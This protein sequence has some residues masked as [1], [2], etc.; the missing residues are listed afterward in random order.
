MAPANATWVSAARA[1][2]R[3]VITAAAAAESDGEAG[4]HHGSAV[5]TVMTWNVQLLAVSVGTPAQLAARAAKLAARIIELSADVVCLQEVFDARARAALLQGLAPA[6]DVAYAPA[7][8][9]R[10]GLVILARGGLTLQATAFHRFSGARGAEAWLFDKGAAGALLL[11]PA[12]RDGEV[13]SDGCWADATLALTSSAASAPKRASCVV[14]INTHTQSN[15]WAPS[16]RCGAWLHRMV[17][18]VHVMALH[19]CRT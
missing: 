17:A 6:Y 3:R 13:D 7:D 15:Y 10:C 19:C 2:A 16:E 11:L 8:A 5:L 14:I 1:S 18:T 12:G 9:A 4:D